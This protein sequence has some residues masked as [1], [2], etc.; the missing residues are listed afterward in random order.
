[1]TSETALEM[2]KRL[3]K[4][5][6]QRSAANKITSKQQFFNYN[7]SDGD[8]I[9]QHLSSIELMTQALSDVGE[10]DT[11]TDKIVKVLVQHIYNN[12]AFM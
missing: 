6:E 9:V 2:W 12:M 7:M 10:N 3:N 11:D 8:S 5:Y 1:M 4:I